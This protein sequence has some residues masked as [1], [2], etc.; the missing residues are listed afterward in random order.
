MYDRNSLYLGLIK[1]TSVALSML[2]FCICF[3]ANI[4]AAKI[5]DAFHYGCSFDYLL[6]LVDV[7]SDLL[8]LN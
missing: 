5:K 8:H 3:A 4:A 7:L 2:E 6:R 1:A